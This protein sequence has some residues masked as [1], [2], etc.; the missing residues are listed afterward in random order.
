MTSLSLCMIVKDSSKTLGEC[1]ESVIRSVDEVVIVDTG[2]TD[3]TKDIAKVVCDKHGVPLILEDYD[4]PDRHPE[5]GW[6]SNFAKPRNVGFALATSEA[7]LWLDDDD[8]MLQRGEDG[9][10]EASATQL[11]AWVDEVFPQGC[12]AVELLYDYGV[13]QMGREVIQQPRVRVV[14]NGS[15]AWASPVHEVTVPLGVTNLDKTTPERPFWVLHKSSWNRESSAERNAWIIETHHAKGEPMTER[16]WRGLASSYR[17]LGRPFDAIEPLKNAIALAQTPTDRAACYVDLGNVLADCQD[18]TGSM[19]ALH[20]AE[21]MAPNERDA[22]FGMARSSL[23]VKRYEDCLRHSERFFAA[24]GENALANR[25]VQEEQIR[26]MRLQCLMET[27][28]WDDARNEAVALFRMSPEKDRW[29]VAIEE[30]EAGIREANL[31]ESWDEVMMRLPDEA[32]RMTARAIRDPVLRAHPPF[33]HALRRLR[34]DKPL[35]NIWAGRT[36]NQWGPRSNETGTGGSEDAVIQ[37]SKRMVDRGWDVSVYGNPPA[38]D[39]GQDSHG[40][41]WLHWSAWDKDDSPDVAVIWRYEAAVEEAPAAGQRWVWLQDLPR[42]Y[43]YD[44]AF[45]DGIDGVLVL[46]E[47]HKSLL[48]EHGIPKGVLTG[49]GVDPDCMVDGPNHKNQFIYCSSP[50]RGLLPLLKAWPLFREAIPDAELHL[51]YGYRDD[52]LSRFTDVYLEQRHEIAKRIWELRDHGVTNHGM[53]GEAE[54]H[55]KMAECGYWLYPLCNDAETFCTTAA[56]IQAC[57]CVPVTS[58]RGSSSLSEVCGEYD[59]GHHVEITDEDSASVWAEE[60]IPKI[61]ADDT[62]RQSMKLWAREHFNWDKV[63]DQWN[64]LFRQ[65]LVPSTLADPVAMSASS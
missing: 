6:I 32:A 48:G 36:P 33:Q 29:R 62:G 8:V 4:D 27:K 61:L 2:S 41:Q 17:I 60:V 39:V 44:E 64:E 30:C 25:P 63:A 28:C 65:G 58:M 55:A 54:L 52:L 49:N 50:D 11:R 34:G 23:M 7:I 14:R 26:A 22:Y 42:R 15:Y 35:L 18:H 19:A 20:K 37:L 46:S 16:L 3:N 53:V 9:Q 31:K 38:E 59:I 47:Y 56:K 24:T 12:D 43:A 13:D 45:C 51:F 1:L 40:V 21:D 10:I 5:H 57:G